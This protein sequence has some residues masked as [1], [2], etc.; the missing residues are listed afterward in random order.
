MINLFAGLILFSV[1][2]AL[3]VAAVP[4]YINPWERLKG[5][6]LTMLVM[7]LVYAGLG[8][9][10]LV[11]TGLAELENTRHNAELEERLNR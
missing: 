11:G 1:V 9:F 5:G 2:V 10:Y 7:W 4:E 6:L 3:F 8:A